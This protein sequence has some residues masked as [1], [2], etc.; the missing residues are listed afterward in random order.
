VNVEMQIG[1]IKE[2]I[3]VSGAVPWSTYKTRP[4]SSGCQ[5]VSNQ[6]RAP[7]AIKV[8]DP[9]ARYQGHRRARRNFRFGRRREQHPRAQPGKPSM[10]LMA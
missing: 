4:H 8:C 10:R 2:T 5:P 7:G 9:D 3:T 1:A 6:F